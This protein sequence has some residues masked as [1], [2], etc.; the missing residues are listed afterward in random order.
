LNVAFSKTVCSSF[1]FFSSKMVDIRITDNM[2][3]YIL[4][5]GKNHL[6]DLVRKL[7]FYERCHDFAIFRLFFANTFRE[8]FTRKPHSDEKCYKI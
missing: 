7:K 6:F 4:G 3:K 2:H 1:L 5:L 8:M